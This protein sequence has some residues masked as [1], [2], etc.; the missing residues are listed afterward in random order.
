MSVASYWATPKPKS[1]SWL[2]VP[3]GNSTAAVH[4]A[5]LNRIVFVPFVTGT[6]I[7]VKSVGAEVVT[8]QGAASTGQ[9]GI[10][11]NLG[12]EYP[13][14]GKL[15]VQC[16]SAIDLNDD[17]SKQ[18]LAIVNPLN[19]SQAFVDLAQGLYW[20]GFNTYTAGGTATLQGDS[21]T[22]TPPGVWMPQ[23]E[24]GTTA[25]ASVSTDTDGVIWAKTSVTSTTFVDYVAGDLT[26]T[27]V[28][29]VPRFY[30]NIA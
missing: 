17:A 27:A 3:Q 28:T 15:V 20:I 6:K 22:N 1:N 14:P 30:F 11:K 5:V 7:R 9:L 24:V 4:V 29:S 16:T 13:H 18:A 26:L 12:I 19:S 23:P 25:F 2:K 10:W 21:T 8:A